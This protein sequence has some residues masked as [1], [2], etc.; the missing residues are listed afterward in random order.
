MKCVIGLRTGGNL[1]N[2]RSEA[3]SEALRSAGHSI[4]HI[5]RSS[6]IKAGADLYV[7]SGFASSPALLSA[8]DQGIPYI[9]MEAPVFRCYDLMTHS[10]WGYGG[11]QGGAWHPP[12]PEGERP[13]PELKP[14]HGGGKLIIG[15]KPTDHSLRG[16]DHVKWI[17][18]K[19]ASL[20]EADFRPH[21]LMVLEDSQETI[22]VA[23]QRYGEV[24]TYSSA[25]GVDAVV[26]GCKAYADS[27]HSLLRHLQGTREDFIHELSWWQAPHSDYS[28]LTGHILSGYEEALHRAQIG[29]IEIPRGKI[30]GQVI[31]RKYDRLVLPETVNEGT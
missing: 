28:S 20:P 27:E 5:D 31:Q 3:L 4:E 12:S 1:T 18:E 17:V 30:D 11:L 24:F 7:Q 21:P 25:V 22:S 23:L 16:S 14:L 13:K 26:A 6:G 19:R 15:Q 8:I 29:D 9:I 2:M 10:S